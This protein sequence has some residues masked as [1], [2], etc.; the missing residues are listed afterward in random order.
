VAALATIKKFKRCNVQAHLQAM[1][2][3]CKEGWLQCAKTS[4]LR[5]KVRERV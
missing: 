2:K 5:I 4:G 3:K 1:G